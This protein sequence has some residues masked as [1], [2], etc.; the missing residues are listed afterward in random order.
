MSTVN[1]ITI[2]RGRRTARYSRRSYREPIAERVYEQ[3]A[4]SF[5]QAA[6]RA[7]QPMTGLAMF[8]AG[9]LGGSML[10][11]LLIAALLG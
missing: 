1:A 6:Y 10:A 7:E 11:A 4:G 3:L 9:M 5:R 2:P 8:L